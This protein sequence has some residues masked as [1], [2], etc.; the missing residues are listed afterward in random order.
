MMAMLSMA[1]LFVAC[2]D[3]EITNASINDD[4]QGEWVASSFS[5][6]GI[7]TIGTINSEVNFT[8]VST[9]EDSG[10]FQLNVSDINGGSASSALTY[11]VLENG[12]RLRLGSDTLN[13]VASSSNL[14]FDG[15]LEGTTTS[16]IA[17][18]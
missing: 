9:S 1:I 17:S 12:A 15:V 10:T 8:F 16:V 2:D 14:N 7:E 13:F 5:E 18:R 6:D 4:I 11:T 3:D